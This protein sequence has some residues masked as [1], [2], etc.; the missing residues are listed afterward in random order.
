L[1]VAEKGNMEKGYKR[2]KKQEARDF[3]IKQK[4]ER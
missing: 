2:N 4:Q 1:L 3:S